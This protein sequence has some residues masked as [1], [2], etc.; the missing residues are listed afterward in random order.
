MP[1][2]NG[3]GTAGIPFHVMNRAARRL[4]LFESQMDY[5]A[6]VFCLAEARAKVPIRL[7]AYCVMPNHFHLVA[8]PLSDGGLS[9]FMKTLLGTHSKRW[10]AFRKSVGEGAVY[11]GRFRAFPVQTDQHFYTVCRYV[12]RNPL[13]AGLVT[14]AEDWPWSSTWQCANARHLVPLDDWPILRPKDWLDLV[15]DTQKQEE[16]KSVRVASARQRPFGQPDWVAA[17]AAMTGVE[18]SLR[19]TGRPRKTTSGTVFG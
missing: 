9:L 5:R 16:E 3:R 8:Q 6:F 10:R 11:Q 19:P 18:A 1:W 15:N 2:R 17:T 13:R 14:K 7:Y 12:E 4:T